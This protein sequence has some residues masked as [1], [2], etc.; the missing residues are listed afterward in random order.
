[1]NRAHQI[2]PLETPTAGYATFSIRA[3]F[4]VTQ[5]HLSHSFAV[6][7]FNL[8]DRLY[9]NHLSLIKELAPEM[10]R[11]FKLLYNVRF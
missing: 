7:A 6:N 3:S 1:V 5:Q 10:G 8:N 9:R 11:N 4:T 2:F